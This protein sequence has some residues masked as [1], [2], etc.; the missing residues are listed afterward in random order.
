MFGKIALRPLLIAGIVVVLS[1]PA[2]AHMPWLASDDDGHAIMW[3]GESPAD[4]TYHLPP[5]IAQIELTNEEAGRPLATTTID[6]DSLVGIRSDSK[7]DAQN[8]LVGT[9]TYGLYHGTKLTYHVE[10]LPNQDRSTWPTNRRKN[11]A[12]QTVITPSEGGGVSVMVLADG[13]PVKD[14]EVKLFCQEG[15]EEATAKTDIAGI[16]I[17]PK[18]AIEPGLNSV[19]ANINKQDVKGEYDG[20]EYSS[21]TDILTA[22]F[23]EPFQNEPSHDQDIAEP[24]KNKISVDPN[25]GVLIDDSGLPEL[26]EELTSFGATITGDQ[27]YVYGGHTGSAH[28]YSV[29][30]Q[31]NRLWSLD[32]SAKDAKWQSLASGPSLQGLA[33]VSRG[34]QIIRIGGFTAVNELGEDH[35]LQSQNSVA[36]YDAASDTWIDLPPLPEPRSSLDAAI[37]G[38]AVYVVGGWKLAGDSDDSQWHTTAW[39]LNLVDANATWK[40]IAQPPFKRRAISAAAHD[41]K[42][43]VIGGM[44]SKS[45]PTTRVDIYDPVTDSWSLGKPVPGSGMSGFGSASFAAAGQ[46]YV[47]TMDGF[48]HRWNSSTNDWDTVAKAD[49]ARFFHR[50]LPIGDSGLLLIGGANMQIGKFTQIDLVSLSKKR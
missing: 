45:K 18:K 7:I 31:S 46:L 25:S 3:F 41:G 15:H 36:R 34:D 24:A 17:F 44:T 43:F 35:N 2:I 50:M 6:N 48:L 13:E 10:H 1:F 37:V 11:A 28:S 27:L 14:V 29:D 22:T 39:S 47:S 8:E 19:M 9:V 16:V 4:R 49:P 20:Q 23:V 42:L 5:P 32:L 21:T 40:P 26:P 30:E 33:L 12:Y 38:D